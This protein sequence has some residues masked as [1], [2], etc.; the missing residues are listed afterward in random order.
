MSIIQSF[1]RNSVSFADDFHNQDTI[2]E[3][4]GTLPSDLY[5]NKLNA[6]TRF[7][8][9]S[10]ASIR[11]SS[12]RQPG[13]ATRAAVDVRDEDAEHAL[14]N[15]ILSQKYSSS[16]GAED[17][18]EGFQDRN[19]TQNPSLQP[20]RTETPNDLE[21]GHIGAFKLGSLRITNGAASPTLSREQ[22]LEDKK[23]PS[24]QK[25]RFPDHNQHNR[26]LSR[27]I[28]KS[29]DVS[30]ESPLRQTQGYKSL[31]SGLSVQHP[32]FEFETHDFHEDMISS[33]EKI[34]QVLDVHENS[35]FPEE[36]T[37]FSLFDVPYSS[38]VTKNSKKRIAVSDRLFDEE[39]WTPS[40]HDITKSV[41]SQKPSFLKA[42]SGYQ[43]NIS[44]QSSEKEII[45]KTLQAEANPVAEPLLGSR[46]FSFT[47]PSGSTDDEMN[48]TAQKNL[49]SSL[50]CLTDKHDDRSCSK[51]LLQS[52]E[53]N[54]RD[55]IHKDF[56]I[57]GSPGF[58]KELR[59]QANTNGKTLNLDTF[60]PEF[61]PN[62]TSNDD[63]YQLRDS[64]NTD[65][66]C[67]YDR[68]VYKQRMFEN[69]LT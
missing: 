51:R 64:S 55:L 53:S 6:N 28:T 35:F 68:Y 27:D 60:N 9:K 34:S 7:K 19:Q 61:H 40:I 8:T 38:P 67:R 43:S 36:L 49:P 37:P 69:I 5:F 29:W 18:G 45:P 57:S 12:L 3:L 66:Q 26:S 48:I 24:I 39:P 33:I 20:Q 58:T 52:E 65:F 4:P 22:V 59:S 63:L 16:S 54:A 41:K 46:S 50:I 10:H 11:A 21:H 14:P 2:H 1:N 17:L 25:R 42:D 44:S 31:S 15:R 23:D 47:T 56:E 13:V 32:N 30:R 62:S